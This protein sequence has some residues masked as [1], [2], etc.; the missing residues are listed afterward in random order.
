[1]RGAKVNFL[2]NIQLT[3]NKPNKNPKDKEEE[4]TRHQS[5]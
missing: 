4:D 3:Q 1:M 2:D 5:I